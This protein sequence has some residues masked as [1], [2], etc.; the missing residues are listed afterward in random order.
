[1]NIDEYRA[2][3]AKENNEG[4]ESV[5]QTE[6]EPIATLEE[7]TQEA[8]EIQQVEQ[9][10]AEQETYAEVSST[11]KYGDQEYEVEQLVRSAQRANDLERISRQLSEQVQNSQ[12]AQSYYNLS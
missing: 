5:V 6:Q 1:M 4:G 9:P 12:T 8:T 7:S 3:V 11:I 2:L 10:T